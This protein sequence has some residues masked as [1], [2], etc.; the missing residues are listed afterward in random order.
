MK[1]ILDEADSLLLH[2]I[3]C[4]DE[5]EIIVDEL[6]AAEQAEEITF[7]NKSLGIGMGHPLTR[8]DGSR[9]LVIRFLQ[10][11]MA[12]QVVDEEYTSGDGTRRSKDLSA[13]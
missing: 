13:N 2:A 1:T 11:P 6:F 7:N 12:W 4:Q 3:V 9:L 10:R 5:L 8:T